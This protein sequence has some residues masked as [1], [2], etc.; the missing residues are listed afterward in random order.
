MCLL[1]WT[2]FISLLNAA[3]TIHYALGAMLAADSARQD[4]LVRS[5]VAVYDLTTRVLC[6]LVEFI[7]CY[8]DVDGQ[9]RAL[10][11]R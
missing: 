4:G 2:S 6:R 7:Y 5:S 10:L 8:V 11:V 3:G 9:W 1:V